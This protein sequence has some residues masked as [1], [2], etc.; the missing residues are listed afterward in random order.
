VSELDELRINAE[1]T[2][3]ALEY[4]AELLISRPED[5][6]IARQRFLIVRQELLDLTNK[7][8][9]LAKKIENLITK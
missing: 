1:K 7:T 5:E 3:G 6:E 8:E 4:Y 2:K 9:Q